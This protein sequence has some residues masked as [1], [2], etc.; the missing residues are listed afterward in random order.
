MAELD[1][2]CTCEVDG[3]RETEARRLRIFH[4]MQ[5]DDM[6]DLTLAVALSLTFDFQ[7][8]ADVAA[9]MWFGVS[10]DTPLLKD[11]L[12]I[13]CDWPYDGLAALWE[14]L[15]A[16][17]PE[18]VSVNPNRQAEHAVAER[19]SAELLAQYEVAEAAYRSHRTTVHPKDDSP[20]CKDC[21]ALMETYIRAHKALDEAWGAKALDG[22][23][24][25]AFEGRG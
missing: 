19:A 4:R 1:M 13:Q 2:V 15:A 14:Q 25:R 5:L 10:L 23:I 20:R 12:Y 3:V 16:Q 17:F 8:S 6:K 21:D 24:D 18:R 7:A 11:G 9:D 22:V